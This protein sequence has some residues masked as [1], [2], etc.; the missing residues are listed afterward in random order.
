MQYHEDTA[1]GIM[2]TEFVS[3][4]EDMTINQAIEELRSMEKSRDHILC[5]CYRLYWCTGR[6]LIS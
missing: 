5:L 6:G 2:T 1:G 4:R 3:V